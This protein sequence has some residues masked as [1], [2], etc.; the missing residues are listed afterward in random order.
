MANIPGD[1]PGARMKVG[2]PTLSR[3]TTCDVFTLSQVYMWCEPTVKIS[4][5]SSFSEVIVAPVWIRALI[6]PSFVAAIATRWVVG[7]R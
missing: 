7:E 1:S 6:A 5:K 3:A 4:T 2:S